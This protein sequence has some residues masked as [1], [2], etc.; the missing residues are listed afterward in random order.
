MII[1]NETMF[2]GKSYKKDSKGNTDKLKKLMS[3]L[4]I[5]ES[6][7]EDKQGGEIKS[8]DTVWKG[9]FGKKSRKAK[10]FKL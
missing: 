4:V 5:Q 8:S 2:N 7:T 9:N 1:R 10:T 6:K 3:E